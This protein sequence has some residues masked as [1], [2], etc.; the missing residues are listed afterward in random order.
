MQQI[1]VTTP[2]DTPPLACVIE[3]ETFLAEADKLHHTIVRL[4]QTSPVEGS[5]TLMRLDEILSNA[6]VETLGHSPGWK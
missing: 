2:F 5:L 1:V 4:L 6:V 3:P